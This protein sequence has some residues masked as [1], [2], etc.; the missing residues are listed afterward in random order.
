[1]PHGGIPKIFL[2]EFGPASVLGNFETRIFC[3]RA[4]AL[5]PAQQVPL[6]STQNFSSML[7]FLPEHHS[8]ELCSRSH[9]AGQNSA[10]RDFCS[11]IYSS[12]CDSANPKGPQDP[13]QQFENE[14]VLGKKVAG[15]CH[16][17]AVRPN[18][19]HYRTPELPTRRR[20]Q[21]RSALRRVL[22]TVTQNGPIADLRLSGRA[23]RN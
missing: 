11:H 8:K 13:Q 12:T 16:H 9:R 21:K 23:E 4:A 10:R 1:M 2:A 18:T 19:T 7:N 6:D 22:A 17:A 5:C 14:N 3:P 15:R 20:L